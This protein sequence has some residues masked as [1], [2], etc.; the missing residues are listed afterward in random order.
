MNAPQRL[1]N[2]LIGREG[3]AEL[4]AHALFAGSPFLEVVAEKV[5]DLDLS[6]FCEEQLARQVRFLAELMRETLAH[7]YTGLSLLAFAHILVALD[8]VVRV[9]DE[10]PDTRVGGYADDLRVVNRVMSDWEKELDE[11][12]AWKLKLGE[13]WREGRA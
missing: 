9:K 11:F 4:P 2:E 7:R 13:R 6:R 10:I 1:L 8:Y 12:R 5:S 3:F